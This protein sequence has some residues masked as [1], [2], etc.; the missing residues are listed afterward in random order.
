MPMPMPMPDIPLEKNTGE[1][2]PK[3]IELFSGDMIKKDVITPPETIS[4]N[5]I[6]SV[7]DGVNIADIAQFYN[8]NVSYS[9]G[10]LGILTAPKN[11]ELLS[12]LSS[13]KSDKRIDSAKLEKVSNKNKPT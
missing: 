7:N 4:G 3:G 10:N 1:Y 13:L 6:I 11:V 12:L 2:G 8:M 5:F 9:V